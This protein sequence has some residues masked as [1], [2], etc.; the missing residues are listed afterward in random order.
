MDIITVPI[1]KVKPWKDNPRDITK[2]GYKR[3]LNQLTELEIYKPL[4]TCLENGFYTVLDGNRR[5]MAFQELKYFEVEIVVVRVFSEADKIKYS[6]SANDNAGITDDQKMAELIYPIKEEINLDDYSIN[7]SDS[8]EIS[9]MLDDFAPGE[10]KEQARLDK[11][12]EK[13]KVKCP[14]CGCEFLP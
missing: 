10:V 3:L 9:R 11:L 4:L 7:I 2:K 13:E 8:I 14:E 5:L 6:L 12:A 1:S